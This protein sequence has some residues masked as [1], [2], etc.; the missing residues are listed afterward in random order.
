MTG[1]PIVPREREEHWQRVWDA[2]DPYTVPT[3]PPDPGMRTRYLLTMFPYPS[4]D[5]HMG[6]AEVFAIE[7]AIARYWRLQGHQV[8]NPIGWDSFGLPAENAAIRGGEHPATYTEQNIATQAASIRRYAVSFDFSRRL[9]THDVTYYRW[10]Q[11]LFLQLYARGLAY[12]GAGWVNWCPQDATV[13]ANEQVIAGHCERCG[14]AVIRRELTQWLVRITDYADRL[15]D[16]M[17]QL[18]GH[19]PDRILTMQ[20]NWIGRSEGVRIRFA[21]DGGDHRA[22]SA[23]PGP[24][25]AT[26]E[27]APP[28]PSAPLEVFTTRPETLAGVTFLAVAPESE[29]AWA[30]CA[31]QAREALTGYRE[32]VATR[33]EIERS[34]VGQ[35][36]T[37]VPLGTHVRH[38]LTGDP[39]PVWAADYVLAGYGTGAVM[40]VPA[41]DDR[42]AA[43]AAAMG[44]PSSPGGTAG[45]GSA[46]GGDPDWPDPGQV[47]AQLEVAGAGERARSYR[48]RDWLV[49]RQRYWGAPI[50]MVHCPACGVVPVP[51]ADLPVQLP[52]LRGSELVP[53]GVSPLAGATEW[54]QV[55]CPACGGPAQRDTDTMDTFVDSSW[56]FLRYLSPGRDDVPFD[57][58]DAN[59][60]MP[61][62]AY[63]GG[64]EHANLH[65]LYSRFI[66]KVLRDAGWLAVDEPFASVIN[67]GA[68][69]SKSLGNGVD[70]A[71][72]LDSYGVD[73][74]RLAILFS[75]PPADDLDW[76]D[77]RPEAMHRFQAR[78]LRLARDVGA[79]G[80]SG[81][82]GAAGASGD[83]GASGGPA[84][85]VASPARVV[86]GASAEAAARPG[87]N[88]SSAS[89]E[90]L[91]VRRTTHRAVA[92]ISELM[93]AQ[94]L[95]VVVARLME[96]V[97][98]GRKAIDTGPGATDPA[99]RELAEAAAVTMSLFAPYTAEEMWAAL[100]RQPSVAQAHWPEVDPALL[101]AD[102]VEAVVQVAG[103]VRGHLQVPATID[104]EELRRQA[105]ELERVQRQLGG[106]EPHR[107]IVR[108]PHLV[109][110]VP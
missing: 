98:A 30:W 5:L 75:G 93:D 68:A 10:T 100:G 77:V 48:L 84:E 108:A 99:V 89:A 65:L 2:L 61:A 1:N 22:P 87:A 62:A 11:W 6:H 29:A 25:G 88:A 37:G 23:H 34:A 91:D 76:A 21:A 59:G 8:L 82:S 45:P 104:A 50:P 55:D 31:P 41:G 36:K 63:V 103:K 86:A 13:L 95:N 58:D 12:R 19:W 49:S 7:D 9:H 107:V 16:D 96:L 18:E 64:V 90:A 69:M 110:V 60:W 92:E 80:D 33:T 28:A 47:V 56:Y 94:R 109:N 70:L 79:A 85:A 83:P 27:A 102:E 105:L 44:I 17:A 67:R 39:V 42:D 3:G 20:R 26:G 24:M 14:T 72:Q 40:G 97:S 101:V 71:A 46:A 35:E 51:E 15:L 78:A 52:D 81:D 106:A 43:F 66:T 73:A 4:G 53:E 74:V 54:L 38:P 32:Q 57:P